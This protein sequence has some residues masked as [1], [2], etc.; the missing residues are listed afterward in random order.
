M[1]LSE[2]LLKIASSRRVLIFM[3]GVRTCDHAVSNDDSIH[4]PL[5]M[6]DKF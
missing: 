2:M 5:V 4:H 3:L 1:P 6:S